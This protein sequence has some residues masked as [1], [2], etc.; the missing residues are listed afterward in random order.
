[1]DFEKVHC[2]TGED[3][4]AIEGHGVAY[5][6]P[7][8]ESDIRIDESRMNVVFSFSWTVFQQTPE[9]ESSGVIDRYGMDTGIGFTGGLR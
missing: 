3:R 2:V 7:E 9:D 6:V 5:I 1:M 4:F 8:A